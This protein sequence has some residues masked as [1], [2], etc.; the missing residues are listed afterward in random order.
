MDLYARLIIA[1]RR[2]GFRLLGRNGGV[3]FDQTGHHTSHG[4]D[5]QGQR[6]YVQQQHVFYFPGQYPTLDSGADGNH[7]IRVHPFIG[8]LSKEFLNDLLHL[9]N[10][11]ATPY[12]NDF[13]NL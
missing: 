3:G 6:S 5:T 1:G 8:L 10:T 7:F 12:Q 13:V 9:G 4:L 11:C 2:E